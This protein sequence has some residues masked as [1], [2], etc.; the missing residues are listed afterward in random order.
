MKYKLFMNSIRKSIIS[1]KILLVLFVI[2]FGITNIFAGFV[3]EKEAELVA[4]NHFYQAVNSLENVDYVA[5]DDIILNCI[6]NPEEDKNVAFYIYNIN[7]N[8]GFVLV[9]SHYSVSPILAYSFESSF[10]LEYISPGQQ[11]FLD[12]YTENIKSAFDNN[13]ISDSRVLNK[14]ESLRNFKSGESFKQKTTV[15][16]LLNTDWNQSWPY[17]A[18]CPENDALASQYNGY[19]AVGCGPLSTAMIMK[20][21]NWPIN[22][23]G[24]KT[25]TSSAN[26]GHG[27]ITV[28]FAQQTY[29]W[30]NMPKKLSGNVNEDLAK[31]LFHVGVGVGAYWGGIGT[32]SATTNCVTALTS[33]FKFSTNIQL[34]YRSNYTY[35]NWKNIMR[36]QINSGNPMIYSGTVSGQQY[37]H[38]FNLDGYQGDDHFHFNFGWG[39][40]NNGFYTLDGITYDA[41]Q[42]AVV[43]IYPRPNE[44]PLNCSG[45]KIITGTEGSFD[46][47]SSHK[48]YLPNLNC[49]Y[50]INPECGDIIELDFD[51][52]ELV[53]GATVEIYNG[54]E[55]ANILI[56]GFDSNNVPAGTIT[57]D[58]GAMTIKF[59]SDDQEPTA[60]GWRAN[61]SVSYCKTN[62]LK[63]K[64]SGNFND[65]SGICEYEK[66]TVCTWIIEPQDANYIIIEFIEF[67]LASGGADFVKVYKNS[68]SSANTIATFTAAA[69]P[70]E[71]V[72]VD[73]GTAVIQF[74]ADSGDVGQGWEINYESGVTE[75]EK[76]T[77]ISNLIIVPNPGDNSS[78]IYMEFEESGPGIFTVYD[79]LG[80]LIDTKTISLK[81]GKNNIRI[82]DIVNGNLES[83]T[84]LINI[85]I[86]NKIYTEKFIIAK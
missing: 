28:N 86:N 81:S 16:P 73:A 76:N 19:S 18:L 64:A 34:I 51:R 22:G 49:T 31:L 80:K 30:E 57:A 41:G 37:G 71:P 70:A 59:I 78:K 55:E 75:I 8:N 65:G 68:I 82:S 38:Q 1:K 2:T 52:F 29:N 60:S 27:D 72:H 83:G 46:D 58:G 79:L 62:I 23:E 5:W 33:Y 17:N 15:E 11:F 35:A 44:F 13:L 85:E 6:V 69:P 32:G 10:N 12:N 67:N 26:G 42:S 7:V 24:T 48:N 47:G 20:Y 45:T 39:G 53:E 63:T 3:T 66:S 25:H 56:A 14:W 61:Y 50:V 4:K 84:Y 43:N 9:S 74:F 54:T 77:F 36:S 40:N 21:Y